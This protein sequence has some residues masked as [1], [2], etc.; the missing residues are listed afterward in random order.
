MT[1]LIVTR[2]KRAGDRDRI[3]SRSGVC[4]AIVTGELFISSLLEMVSNNV[5]V[6][7]L[8]VLFF[9]ETVRKMEGDNLVV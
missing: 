9:K 4:R 3:L 6:W 1:E 7:P 2:L 8:S 5:G